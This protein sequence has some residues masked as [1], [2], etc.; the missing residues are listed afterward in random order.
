M[1]RS[2]GG[3]KTAGARPERGRCKHN[4]TRTE[5]KAE[6]NENIRQIEECTR[7]EELAGKIEEHTSRKE[8]K[9]GVV[10]TTARR[11]IEKMLTEIDATK[12]QVEQVGLENEELLKEPITMQTVETIAKKSA[13]VNLKLKTF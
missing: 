13:Q 7:N 1:D 2:A 5:E 4:A 10:G 6:D 3:W 12:G 9:A 11:C 8:G